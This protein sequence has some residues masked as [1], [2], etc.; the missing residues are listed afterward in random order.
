MVPGERRAARA[1]EALQMA[2]FLTQTRPVCEPVGEAGY[3]VA[4]RALGE[5]IPPPPPAV[6]ELPRDEVEVEDLPVREPTSETPGKCAV[7][8]LSP[9]LIPSAW[10]LKGTARRREAN[11]GSRRAA[12][13]SPRHVPGGDQGTGLGSLQTYIRTHREKDFEQSVSKDAGVCA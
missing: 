8:L 13:R 6:P 3:W 12:G 4:R 11:Q 9:V 10:R 5:V 2:V 1:D 7:R